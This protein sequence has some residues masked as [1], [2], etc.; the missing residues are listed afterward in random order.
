MASVYRIHK[1]EIASGTRYLVDYRDSAGRRTKRRFTKAR[2]AEAFKKQVVASSHTGLPIPRPVTITFAVWAAEWLAQKEALSKA[3]KKPRPSTLYSWQSDLK[4]LLAYFGDYKLHTITTEAIVRY[5]EYRQMTP[6]AKGLRSGGKPPR[7]K[8]I[9]N[10]VGVLSQVLCSAKARHIIPT[11]PARD[12]DWHELLG[13]EER[14]HRQYRDIPLTPAQVLHFLD[15]AK[16]KY[17]PKGHYEPTGPYYPL[18]E[19]DCAWES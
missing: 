4:S 15:V 17:T 2:D 18:F 9:R 11:N 6:I 7:D 19:Q 3:G 13:T 8:S 16:A 1:E 12:L 5:V 14:Y 10:K